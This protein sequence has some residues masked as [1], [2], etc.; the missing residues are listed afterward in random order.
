MQ[1]CPGCDR[2]VEAPGL[3][4]ACQKALSLTAPIG[5]G[6]LIDG[7]WR[8]KRV[9]GLGGMGV[10]FL[11]EDEGL[12]R[13][14]AVKVLSGH[15]IE[16][17]LSLQRFMREA[18]VMA[19]LEHPNLVPVYAAGN[20]AQRPYIVMKFLEGRSLWRRL[21]FDE[22]RIELPEIV[23]ITRQVCDALGYLHALGFIH[24]DVKP[25][26]V[27]LGPNGRV[28][29]LDF[30][31]L[32]DP[33]LEDLTVTG[34]RPGTPSFMA[35]EVTA[36]LHVDIRSDIYS[37]GLLLM[38]ALSGRPNLRTESARNDSRA[39]SPW[40]PRALWAVIDRALAPN[41]EDRFQTAEAFAQAVEAVARDEG[42]VLLEELRYSSGSGVSVVAG[43]RSF[44]SEP[45]VP[46]V[47]A[48]NGSVTHGRPLTSGSGSSSGVASQDGGVRRLWKLAAAGVAAILLGFAV[49]AL[50]TWAT[51]SRRAE[52]ARFE[53][54]RPSLGREQPAENSTSSTRAATD[55]RD[56]D[57]EA[58]Q[59]TGATPSSARGEATVVAATPVRSDG[60]GS[61]SM[62]GG[63]E[64]AR[65]GTAAKRPPR[66]SWSTRR[67]E[68]VAR[69]SGGPAVVVRP[70]APASRDAAEDA[71]T[72]RVVTSD[73]ETGEGTWATLRVDGIVRG[74]TPFQVEL[75]PG[76]HKIS[77][78][79]AGFQTQHESLD[80]VPG[81]VR[82]LKVELLR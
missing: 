3:C 11:A 34:E 55:E 13:Q 51:A 25:S 59:A 7:K 46:L 68:K 37:L 36:G 64:S 26:N 50:I 76:A 78:E 38:H 71:A 42:V 18:K 66:T 57:A 75:A 53:E 28:T 61:P 17:P 63:P 9:I 2:A 6:D 60:E 30:G 20:F 72:L 79:R 56:S 10:V 1:V 54:A 33:T 67:S 65:S 23:R 43:P 27:F 31:I 21:R 47:T 35:P 5:L 41:P 4:V 16:D 58:G 69:H 15:H 22:T 12:S 70:P 14:V 44:G 49:A 81:E 48:A 80:L 29:L 39:N 32:K 8:V 40:V 82:V 52:L 19:K 24:R 77:L 45:R 62:R 74:G 73:G